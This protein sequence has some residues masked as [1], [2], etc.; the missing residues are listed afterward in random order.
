MIVLEGLDAGT[1]RLEFAADGSSLLGSSQDAP[2]RT[3][4]WSLP[5]GGPPRL[6]WADVREATYCPDGERF[7]AVEARGGLGNP[8][9]PPASSLRV[10]DPSLVAPDPPFARATED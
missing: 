2:F 7:L 3:A 6:S 5:D 4:L 10:L 8:T 1:D 9:T